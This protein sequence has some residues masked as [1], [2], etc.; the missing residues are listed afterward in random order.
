MRESCL[1]LTG[2]SAI[3]GGSA[4]LRHPIIDP[5]HAYHVEILKM[6]FPRTA[7]MMN[8]NLHKQSE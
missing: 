1:R 3:F 2:K 5:L 6:N 7:K 8:Q 4:V